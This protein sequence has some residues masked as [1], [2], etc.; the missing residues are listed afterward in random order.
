MEKIKALWQNEHFKTAIS[1]LIVIIL[2]LAFWFG[3]IAYFNNENPYLVVSSGSM[4]PT[5]NVGDLIIVKR[6]DPAQIRIGDII[7]FRKPLDP[8]K[9]I[10]HRVVKIVKKGLNEYLFTTHG[11]NNPP[12][13]TESFSEDYYVGKVIGR[14]PFI[15]HVSLF[16][17]TRE[18]F[19][20]LIFVIICLIITFILLPSDKEKEETPKDEEDSHKILNLDF[21]TFIILNLLII[22]LIAFSLWGVFSFWQPGAEVGFQQVTIRGMYADLEYHTSFRDIKEVFLIHGLLTYRIDCELQDGSIRM[23]ITTFSWAQFFVLVLVLVNVR[24]IIKVLR[25]K[26]FAFMK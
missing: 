17:H 4:F 1:A 14:I 20:F 24:S 10:V 15:G 19:Y 21:I 9:L 3:S 23:G 26:K 7:V 12:T 22:G 2:F 11:D 25:T 16:T 13:A 18:G 6:I 5:L 8:E